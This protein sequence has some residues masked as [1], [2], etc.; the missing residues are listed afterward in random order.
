MHV[1]STVEY[2]SGVMYARNEA[3]SA[4][5]IEM[6]ILKNEFYLLSKVIQ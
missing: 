2:E 1:L 4:Q 5:N 6:K 3:V